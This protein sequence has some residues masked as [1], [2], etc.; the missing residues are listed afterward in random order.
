[1]TQLD[2]DFKRTQSS[3]ERTPS[4]VALKTELQRKDRVKIIEKKFFLSKILFRKLMIL[5]KNSMKLDEIDLIKYISSNV[6]LKYFP[7]FSIE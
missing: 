4:N 7:F 1:M 5:N 6:S 3:T 2:P